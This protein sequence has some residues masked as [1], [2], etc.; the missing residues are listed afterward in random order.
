MRNPVVGPNGRAPDP[1]ARAAGY[2]ILGAVTSTILI[3]LICVNTLMFRA[4]LG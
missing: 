1:I 4:L 2:L 3:A